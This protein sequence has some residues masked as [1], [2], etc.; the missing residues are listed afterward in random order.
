MEQSITDIHLETLKAIL[1]NVSFEHKSSYD[2]GVIRFST[3]GTRQIYLKVKRKLL[4]TTTGK[5]DV[6]NNSRLL[7]PDITPDEFVKVLFVAIGQFEAHEFCESFR[8][9]G[10]HAYFPHDSDKVPS[11]YKAGERFNLIL[12]EVWRD[13]AN[14]RTDLEIARRH[15]TRWLKGTPPIRLVRESIEGWTIIF[16]TCIKYARTALV[17]AM[18][19][20]S[21]VRTALSQPKQ[22]TQNLAD[23]QNS[24]KE[25]AA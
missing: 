24:S 15:A 4:S 9:Y 16:D 7:K 3:T 21:M 6:I 23:S 14:N 19:M 13:V 1:D 22:A 2:I 18:T 25:N 5:M 12:L 17:Y 10:T 20:P 11:H 8:V